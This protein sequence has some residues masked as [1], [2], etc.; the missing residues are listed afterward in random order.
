[1][2]ILLLLLRVKSELSVIGARYASRLGDR[3]RMA[4][5]GDFCGWNTSPDPEIDAIF[6]KHAC[7]RLPDLSDIIA[8]TETKCGLRPYVNDGIIMLGR[9]PSL[10]NAFVNVCP[11]FNGWKI[12][13]GAGEV[14]ARMVY[15]GHGG[16]DGDGD[17]VELISPAGR[18]KTAPLWSSIC[19][20]RWQ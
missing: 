13:V 4:S 15:G 14:I 8:A 3:V 19:I 1:M 2:S 20:Q 9:L 18:V 6:R 7:D 10:D 16:Y 17:A 12:C 5:V 11:G